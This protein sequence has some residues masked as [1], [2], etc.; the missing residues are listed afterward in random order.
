MNPATEKFNKKGY[1]LEE[2][3]NKKS[4]ITSNVLKIYNQDLKHK[5]EYDKLKK[6]S[7]I[8]E[9]MARHKRSETTEERDKRFIMPQKSDPDLNNSFDSFIY[10]FNSTTTQ[11]PTFSI[12]CKYLKERLKNSK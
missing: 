10:G 5:E 1:F 8:R 11:N 9:N 7:E 4:L 12:S 2:S 3:Y 6:K